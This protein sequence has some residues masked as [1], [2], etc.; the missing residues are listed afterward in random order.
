MLFEIALALIAA[1]IFEFVFEKLKQPGII[2]ELIAGILL[3][4]CVLGR[5]SGSNVSL[6]GIPVFNFNF[7]LLSPEFRELAFIGIVFLLFIIGLETDISELKKAGRPGL[8]TAIFSLAIPFLMGFMVGE[9]FGLSTDMSLAIGTIIFCSSITISMRILSDLDLLSTR[10]G[11]TLQAAAI[12][13]D[14]IGLFIFSLIIYRANPFVYAFRLLLFLL[15]I[16][17]IGMAAIKY[18][19]K[20]GYS[21]NAFA[22]VLPVGLIVCFL[23]AAIAEDIGLA[24]II[25]AFVAGLFIKKTPQGALITNHIKT[26]GQAFF[27]PL[28]F[29]WVGASFNFFSLFSA[30]FMKIFAFI[31]FFVSFGLLGNFAGGMIGARIAGLSKRES[32][33]IGIATMPIM[34]MSLVVA[35]ASIERGIFGDPS[36]LI[37]NQVKTATLLLIITSCLLTPFLLK[38]SIVNDFSKR[39][40]EIELLSFLKNY[41]LHRLRENQ[42]T[43]I[44][45]KSVMRKAN[46]NLKF[47]LIM[48][49]LEEMIFILIFNRFDYL[50]FLVASSAAILGSFLGYFSLRYALVKYRRI[51]C[52]YDT[53]YNIA[54][55]ESYEYN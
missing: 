1:K 34:G 3:G 32:I 15:L 33:S 4:P 5:L 16:V 6:F 27:I 39:R 18:S 11:L 37:A 10:I 54:R 40:G 2:G 29:V 21:R 23:F 8:L 24:A 45:S 47:I 42:K 55:R 46:L 25:G 31:I 12:F 30:E 35:T 22:I 26:I 28:F 50:F 19:Q 14:L 17:F 48:A 13:S 38:K 51:R 20:K 43:L 9:I 53:N 36:G 7:N 44:K 41:K 52:I 49:M